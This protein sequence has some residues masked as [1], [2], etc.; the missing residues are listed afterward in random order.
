MTKDGI[1][2]GNQVRVIEAYRQQEIENGF[3]GPFQGIVVDQRGDV[4]WLDESSFS[5]AVLRS[6]L[7]IV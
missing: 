4:V 7:E 6:H 1:R 3:R 5:R 2:K